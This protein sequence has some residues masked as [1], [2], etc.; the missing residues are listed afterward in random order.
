MQLRSLL[1]LPL[2]A[3]AAPLP[4]SPAA[5]IPV[6]LSSYSF[7]PSA[8]RIDHGQSIVLRLTND[9]DRGHNFV[10]REFFAAARIEPASQRLVKRGA[11]EVARHSTVEVRML[12]PAAGRYALSCTHFTHAM[13]GMTGEILVR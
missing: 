5:V 9:S 2:L 4:A 6:I 1:V 3:A 8:V 7:T 13:R 11:V 10:A 12:A